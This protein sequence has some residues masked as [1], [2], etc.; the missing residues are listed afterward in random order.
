MCGPLPDFRKLVAMVTVGILQLPTPMVR[1]HL[2][3][4]LGRFPAKRIHRKGRVGI[5]DGD[6]TGTALPDFI[7][8][9]SPAH[10][11]KCTNDL[12]NAAAVTSAKIDRKHTGLSQLTQGTQMPG[13]EIDHMNE[14]ADSG[15]VRRVVVV[16]PD[17]Q[18]LPPP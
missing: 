2:L 5:A 6:I 4:R 15:A 1:T 13:C 14:V 16:S 9:R 11:L 18:L 10:R 17:L 3:Q 7:G 8:D 12:H